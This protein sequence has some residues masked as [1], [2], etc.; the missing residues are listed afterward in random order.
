MR[1]HVPSASIPTSTTQVRGGNGYHNSFR[2]LCCVV[3]IARAS[4]HAASPDDAVENKGSRFSFEFHNFRHQYF[5]TALQAVALRRPLEIALVCASM[6]VLEST[7]G[8]A[9]T[10]ECSHPVEHNP[11]RSF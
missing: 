7:G 10:A 9:C 1:A 4:V 11:K 5:G 3:D 6:A 2:E 8:W